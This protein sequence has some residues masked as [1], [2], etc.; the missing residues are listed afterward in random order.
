MALQK[1]RT[2]WVFF[3]WASLA[4]A[5]T[6]LGA[7]WIDIGH[8]QADLRNSLYRG[9]IADLAAAKLGRSLAW[10]KGL[11]IGMMVVQLTALLA[12]CRIFVN[13][14]IADAIAVTSQADEQKAE[15]KRLAMV[16]ERTVNGVV[17]TDTKA[18]VEWINRGFTR[19][20]GYTLE[21]LKGKTAGVT[22]RS[23][24][25]DPNT[26]ARMR[27]AISRGTAFHELLI[28]RAKDGREYWVEIE[29]EPIYDDMGR[30]TGFMA[31]E[32]DVT[33]RV[34][35]EQ[36]LRRSEQR[37]RLATDAAEIGV[38]EYDDE[39]REMRWSDTFC[40]VHGLIPGFCKPSLELWASLLHRKD[41]AN[42][43]QEMFATLD[44]GQ[45]WRSVIKMVINGNVRYILTVANIIEYRA[46]KPNRKSG[47]CLDVTAEYTLRAETEHQ[48]AV[49]ERLGEAARIGA[50]EY[51]PASKNLVFSPQVRKL[52]DVSDDYVPELSTALNFYA[53]EGRDRISK[54]VQMAIESGEPYDLELPFVTAKGRHLWVR[55]TG[56][57]ERDESGRVVKLWGV[58][59]DITELKQTALLQEHAR[60]TAEAANE[61][62][63][64]FLANMSHEI[65]TPLVS[66]LGYTELLA[67]EI[68]A[69]TDERARCIEV[70]RRNG[71]HLAALVN[72]I[73][74]YSKINAAGVTLHPEECSPSQILQDVSSMLR[75]RAL[76]KGVNLTVSIDENVPTKVHLD[77]LRLRQILVN[78]TGNAVKFTNEGSVRVRLS[79]F[80]PAFAESDTVRA[81][82]ADPEH[83]KQLIGLRFTVEDT[84]PG[85]KPA[86]LATLFKPF[87]QGD[88]TYT[89][90]HGGTGLGLVISRAFARAMGGDIVYDNHYQNGSRFVVTL[91]S[92]RAP[93]TRQSTR[94]VTETDIPKA[95]VNTTLSS[96]LPGMVLQTQPAGNKEYT[97]TDQPQPTTT[98]AHAAQPQD[99]TALALPPATPAEK[100][101]AGMRILL[102][103]DS[104]DSQRLFNAFL[105]KA[106]ADLT[107]VANGEDAVNAVFRANA[108]GSPYS[109]ILMDI[110]MPVIDGHEATKRVRRSDIE[111]PIIA[112][113]AHASP[114]DIE[115]SVQAG[116]N[117]HLTK[118][119]K[120]DK[121]I[122]SCKQWAAA[123]TRDCA[124][125]AA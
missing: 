47:I 95:A 68:H 24:N 20:S 45:D 17:I 57:P 56:R 70:I 78:L 37:L 74:D 8:L 13:P 27:Q 21:E 93:A 14:A 3:K 19:I 99:N 10:L 81:D 16:V 55:A 29:A 36:Q 54:A 119:I 71:E 43:L 101:L 113:T 108:T 72:D 18:R 86:T 96:L 6:L 92:A 87:T 94:R 35:L 73:L 75:Q 44:R 33:E 117:D 79:I 100:P 51:Y 121:L 4:V 90:Q 116:C 65:R 12:F 82:P 61:Q 26:A 98:D 102:A 104:P 40:R 2:N 38:W 66:I 15:L 88:P 48:L 63:S 22:L 123:N 97:T 34:Q 67:E 52:H 112:L 59:Q 83:G 111:T 30:L 84:G 105:Q 85:I 110:Q 25:T 91:L 5:F 50:W 23:E 1:L 62:K 106:G 77:P 64:L 69:T 28:N 103:E 58:F 125:S 114:D 124:R 49:L 80:E 11:I 107:I 122:N 120:R 7:V 42:A 109:L 41:S 32:T 89:R 39:T 31:I 115:R 53:S 46:G 76:N 9:E 60:R 118:P